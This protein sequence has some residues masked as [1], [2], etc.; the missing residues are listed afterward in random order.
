MTA[1]RVFFPYECASGLRSVGEPCVHLPHRSRISLTSPTKTLSS[2]SLGLGV[3]SS[4]PYLGVQYD[5]L[6]SVSGEEEALMSLMSRME[7]P[8]SS[9]RISGERWQLS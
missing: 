4:V 1:G 7:E 3:D 9:G 2:S 8:V 5:S 6:R